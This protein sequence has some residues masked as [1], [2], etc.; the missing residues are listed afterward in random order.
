MKAFTNREKDALDL[1]FLRDYF[2]TTG[3]RPPEV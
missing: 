1:I 2:A 3:E